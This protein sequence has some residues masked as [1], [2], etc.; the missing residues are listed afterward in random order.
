MLLCALFVRLAGQ[1]PV[2]A[3]RA[4]VFGAVG[5]KTHLAESLGKTIPLLMT[6]LSVAIAFRA[7]FFNVGAEGQFLIGALVSIA[8]ATKLNLPI[9][10]TLVGGALGGALW[11]LIPGLMKT[12]RGA[13][14]IITTIMLNYTAI[15]IASYA[16]QGP[17]KEKTGQLTQTDVLPDAAQLPSIV[18]DTSLHWG[19]L[20]ALL[21]VGLCWWLL[22]RTERGFLWRAVG[23]NPVAAKAAGVGVEKNMLGAVALCGAL[24]GL[25][26]AMEIAG[27]TKF[28]GSQDSFG[29]GYTA[30]AVALLGDLNPLGVVPAALLFGMLNAGGGAM[31]RNANVPAVTVNIVIGV[32]IFVIAAVPKLRVRRA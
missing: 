21:C 20:V 24:A 14:E 27:A 2:T 13:P 29:Y 8:L 7:G 19:L 3:G 18:A 11:A 1:N 26:G 22:F 12:R 28:L 4:L 10:A 31:E 32:V 23:A 5:T 16:V 6:G 15:Q 30:I 25:G 9:Y 17:L